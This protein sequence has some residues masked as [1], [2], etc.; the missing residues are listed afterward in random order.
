MRLQLYLQVI[1]YT[2]TSELLDQ[3]VAEDR[4]LRDLPQQLRSEM[5][6]K[7]VPERRFRFLLDILHRLHLV[8]FPPIEVVSLAP[9][10]GEGGVGSSGA[11]GTVEST[12]PE[13]RAQNFMGPLLLK[14]T[15]GT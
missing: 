4:I 9:A 1:G 2:R 10:A 7:R 3:C 6:A 11:H 5:F 12:E 8:D 15:I 13:Q 14:R